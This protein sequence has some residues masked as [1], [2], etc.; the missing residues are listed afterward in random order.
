MVIRILDL[1][2]G[3]NTGDQGATTYNHLRA[4]FAQG[5]LVVVSFDGLKV[6]T[7]SFVNAAF[8]ALLTEFSL[9]DLKGRMRVTKSTRQIN[10]MIKW[11]L[12]RASA[13]AAA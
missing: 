4:A 8:V 12:D 13:S 3:A 6:A 11:R 7:S 5:D 10:D 9:D 2:D 1:V